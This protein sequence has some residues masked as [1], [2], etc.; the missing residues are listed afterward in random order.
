MF[1]RPVLLKSNLITSSRRAE[2]ININNHSY[3]YAQDDGILQGQLTE[4][5]AV[6]WPWAVEHLKKQIKLAKLPRT[7]LSAEQVVLQPADKQHTRD[8][9]LIIQIQT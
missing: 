7:I 9:N 6:L 3:A 8:K 4:A 2:T 5:L 1:T